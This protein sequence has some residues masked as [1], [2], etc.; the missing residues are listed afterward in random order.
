MAV[1]SI[2]R[3][4]GA[5]GRTLGKMLAEELGYEFLD[6]IALDLLAQKAQ[7]WLADSET[8]SSSVSQ[9]LIESFS[10]VHT[11]NYLERFLDQDK[12]SPQEI[13]SHFEDLARVVQQ[14]AEIGNLVLLGRAA[15]SFWSTIQ[16]A[17]GAH[18]GRHGKP[19]L[20]SDRRLQAE[21]P[22]G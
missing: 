8:G 22:A 13:S 5:G 11:A 20:L 14:L 7:V 2:S 1:V 19:D 4:F 3:Q 21:H 17:Q 9:R 18:G 16:G 10:Q 6:E 12:R 15:S